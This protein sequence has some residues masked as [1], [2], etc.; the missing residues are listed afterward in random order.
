MQARHRNRLDAS[1]GEALMPSGGSVSSDFRSDC[2]RSWDV[3]DAAEG[4]EEE[5]DDDEEEEEEE[6]EEDGKED[7]KEDGEAAG[8]S[9]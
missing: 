7:G 9:A 1:S 8:G 6:D 5:D 2:S 4:G 3:R